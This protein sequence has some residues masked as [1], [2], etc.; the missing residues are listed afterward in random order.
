MADLAGRMW[1][2]AA[3]AWYQ[4]ESGA[5]ADLAGRAQEMDDLR[6]SL[7]AELAAGQE[8]VPAAMEMTLVAHCYQRLGAHAVN[9]AR[10]AAYLAGS[11]DG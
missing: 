11:T 8:T 7:A 9:I 3:D 10:R 4:R 1:R 2:Q 5:A 6:T